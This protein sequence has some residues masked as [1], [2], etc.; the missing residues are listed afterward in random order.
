MIKSVSNYLRNALVKFEIETK[1]FDMTR[2]RFS[3]EFE[4]LDKPTLAL[5]Y[6]LIQAMYTLGTC[7]RLVEYS[8]V[9]IEST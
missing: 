8:T 6:I 2:H 3:L 1:L 5:Q 9:K 4:Q 7:T